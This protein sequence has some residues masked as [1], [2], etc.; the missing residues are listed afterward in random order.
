MVD[1]RVTVDDAQLRAMTTRFLADTQKEAEDE[2]KKIAG[3]FARHLKKNVPEV[4]GHLKDTI[5]IYS[6]NNGDTIGTG[7]S[8]G[9]NTG[10]AEHAR[11]TEFGYRAANGTI[12]AGQR[13]FYPLVAKYNKAM[14]SALRRAM[15][16]IYARF[17]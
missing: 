12:V 13:F 6:T 5:R 3:R 17:S 7:V 9:D 8:I 16:R 2:T 10:E 4:E 14:K 11:Y 15:K 1:W